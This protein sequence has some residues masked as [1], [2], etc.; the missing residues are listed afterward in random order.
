ML[1]F[2]AICNTVNVLRQR[3]DHCAAFG[4]QRLLKINKDEERRSMFFS[5]Q[6]NTTEGLSNVTRMQSES[7][8]SISL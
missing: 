8:N 1:P 3:K 6:I 7:N 2:I 5:I 4:Q